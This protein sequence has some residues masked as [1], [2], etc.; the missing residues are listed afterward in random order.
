MFLV[1]AVHNVRV[2]VL[3]VLLLLGFLGAVDQAQRRFLQ[4]VGGLHQD[5]T[6]P[7]RRAGGLLRRQDCYFPERQAGGLS[8]PDRGSQLVDCSVLRAAGVPRRSTG[9]SGPCRTMKRYGHEKLNSK[10]F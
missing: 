6:A 8:A 4:P 3:H 5:K 7:K 9:D 2:C 1:T 10:L